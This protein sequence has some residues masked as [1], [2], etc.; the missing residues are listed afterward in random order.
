VEGGDIHMETGVGE[1]IWDVEESEGWG[2]II[3]NFKK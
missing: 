1:E 2:N 3:Q